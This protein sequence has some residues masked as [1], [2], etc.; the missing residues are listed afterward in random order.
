MK[1]KYLSGMKRKHYNIPIFVPEL[2]CPHQCV[3]CNQRKIT[4]RIEQPTEEQVVETIETYLSTI[5]Y[6]N[7]EV[8]IAFFGGNFTGI[9]IDDQIK[10]LKVVSP[11]M[12]KGIVQ[13]LRCSTR[14][15]YIDE[16]R[17]ELLKRYGMKTIELGAQSFDKE[18]LIKSGRGHKAEA[19]EYA[20]KIIKDSGISLG[21]QMMIGLPGDSK[22]KSLESARRIIELGADNTR[23]YPTVVIKGTKLEELY[24]RGEYKPLTME[25]AVAQSKD[26]VLLFEEANVTVLRVGLHPS[27]GL[28][29]GDEL[30]AGPFHQSF[31][32]FV[33]SEIWREKF[34]K[35]NFQES[36]NSSIVI[37]VPAKELNYAIGYKGKNRVELSERVGEVKFVAD[38]ELVG[39]EFHVCNC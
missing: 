19:V 3:F 20:S 9:P 17:I 37:G 6:S 29:S 14:P 32:E 11:Y 2:A 13:G 1:N 24:E 12:E 30:V 31:K 4:G 36:S 22:T 27:E 28:L 8:E 38:K 35:H 21:L 7:S 5:D 23:I 10:Y 18:V 26:L 25:E 33:L 15:D 16:E 34:A 39:R